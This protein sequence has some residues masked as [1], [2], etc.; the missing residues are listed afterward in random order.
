[1]T[2]SSNPFSAIVEQA[3]RPAR[4]CPRA[5][6]RSRPPRATAS[7]A[8]RDLERD[9]V[10]QLGLVDLDG[11][12]RRSSPGRPGRASRGRRRTGTRGRR[13]AFQ[14]VPVGAE[15]ER[16]SMSLR[17]RTRPAGRGAAGRRRRGSSP[18]PAAPGGCGRSRPAPAGSRAPSASDVLVRR[19]AA[20][21]VVGERA[22]DVHLA[23]PRRGGSAAA[24]ARCAP[25]SSVRITSGRA[26]ST[27][28]SA[29]EHVVV[30]GG[31]EREPCAAPR[32]GGAASARGS[33]PRSRRAPWRAGR[34]RRPRVTSRLHRLPE[35][36]QLVVAHGHRPLRAAD[37]RAHLPPGEERLGERDL[38]RRDVL[39]ERRRAPELGGHV[40]E[41]VLLALVVVALALGVEREVRE[42]GGA[43]LDVLGLHPAPVL[44]GL[45]DV[46]VLLGGDGE[47]LVEG[48]DAG[49]GFEVRGPGSGRPGSGERRA[50]A[51][52]PG[53]ATARGATSDAARARR[54]RRRRPW[55]PRGP[56]TWRPPCA[57]AATPRSRRGACRRPAR[58]S[59]SAASR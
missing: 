58:R 46:A 40:L 7:T 25:G 34:R 42:G 56:R 15:V 48:E 52:R 51:A 38:R 53:C 3:S 30:G 55:R 39:L 20:P 54:G 4:R 45:L 9:R 36:A 2:P 32:R 21:T 16:C 49:P 12:R 26:L 29:G 27:A 10:A 43:L 13:P 41:E 6:S 14:A 37:R 47:R 23:A 33:A 44:L 17:A 11:L 50:D 18:A 35:A 31:A 59:A 24:R 5:P 57:A 1:M 19:A 8:T 28:T 22:G